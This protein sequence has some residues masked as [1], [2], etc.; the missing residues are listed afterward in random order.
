YDAGG[1]PI[2]SGPLLGRDIIVSYNGIDFPTVQTQ[3]G[4]IYTLP[5][6]TYIVE[7]GVHTL[8][9]DFAGSGVYPAAQTNTPIEITYCDGS[10]D[11]P[12]SFWVSKWMA[13]SSIETDVYGAILCIDPNSLRTDHKGPIIFVLDDINF[14]PGLTEKSGVMRAL[15]NDNA[16]PPYPPLRPRRHS[17]GR[18]DMELLKAGTIWI[19]DE[20]EFWIGVQRGP[21]GGGNEPYGAWNPT[22]G[23]D[24]KGAGRRWLMGGYINKRYYIYTSNGEITGVLIGKDYMDV[25]KDQI[26]GTPI[27]PRNYTEAT[28][29]GTIARQVVEDIN[30][31]QPTGWQYT[32]HP[33]YFPASVESNLALDYPAGVTSVKVEDAS[34]FDWAIVVGVPAVL[35]D[36]DSQEVVR[37]IARDLDN[38]ILFFPTGSPTSN[39]YT[40][41]DGAKVIQIEEIGVEWK[42]EF[43]EE[44]SESIM[45]EICDEASYEW[46]IDYRRRVML[47]ARMSAPW[48]PSVKFDTNIRR[49]PEIVMGDT[50]ERITHAIVTEAAI[51]SVPPDI[52]AWCLSPS[53]WQDYYNTN[54]VY[55]VSSIPSPPKP[56]T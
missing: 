37:I 20:D 23:D 30:I 9:A 16:Y 14:S 35:M 13:P 44:A 31:F 24:G 3:A 38:N 29:L 10:E 25:W 11:F 6:D 32:C 56:T 19:Q 43:N 55:S 54:R 7:A 46:R 48:A 39:A 36:S 18:V 22:G 21:D 53:Q 5:P 34:L 41:I 50:T 17:E 15:I 27:I 1:V 40:M 51:S 45:T 12:A 33:D 2:D 52:D 49:A 42:K 28:D 47:Y 4:G 26:F 8:T